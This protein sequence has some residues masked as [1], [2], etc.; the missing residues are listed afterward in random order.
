MTD[1][2]LTAQTPSGESVVATL[3]TPARPLG[4]AILLHGHSSSRNNSTN[5]A[6]SPKLLDADLYVLRFDFRGHNDSEGSLER[7]TISAGVE[8]LAAVRS[9]AYRAHPALQSLPCS[10]FGSSFGGA[11]AIVAAQTTGVIGLVLK[12][13]VTDIAEMQR[14]RK[15]R[16]GML[17]WRL[18]GFTTVAG[19]K[20]PTRLKYSYVADA[21]RYDL[22]SIARNAAVPVTI[23]HGSS[24]EVV[25]VTQSRR[26]AAALGSRATLTILDG[27][28]HRYSRR[29]DFDRM[30]DICTGAIIQQVSSTT[31]AGPRA[32]RF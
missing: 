20:G 5:L 16:L 24:D 8:D 30:I 14:L 7:L 17:A 4:L 31:S 19:S 9:A 12:S 25:P 18:R 22:Y 21:Q 29:E 11:V 28:D 27:V 2:T 26:L 32:A 6:L 10:L 3:S 1:H 13:P 15:G 23:V